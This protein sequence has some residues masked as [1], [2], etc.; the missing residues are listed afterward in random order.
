MFGADS[1]VTPFPTSIG[2][3]PPSPLSVQGPLRHLALCTN[4]IDLDQR[5]R[6]QQPRAADGGARRR[7]LE[8]AL[9]HRIEAVEV[10]EVGEKH[11][12]LEHLIERGACGLESLFQI[13]ED[14]RG[15]QLDVRAIERKT[16]P[17]ARLRRNPSF[18]IAGELACGEYQVANRD[19]LVVI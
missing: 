14:V 7:L 19:R 18:E 1:V 8:I 12:R 5:I 15:L 6:D 17:L 4:E 13:L 16:G 10:V 11:L 3:Q 9:P 2:G